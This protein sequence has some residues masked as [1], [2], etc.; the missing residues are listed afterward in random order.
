M[1]HGHSCQ[2]TTLQSMTAKG[3]A[4]DGVQQTQF[5]PCQQR[6]RGGVK[7]GR[8][9]NEAFREANDFYYAGRDSKDKKKSPRVKRSES[10]SS[11]NLLWQDPENIPIMFDRSCK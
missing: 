7:R 9:T 8:W 10:Y 1:K 4:A 5:K 6:G 2:E 11:S 3:P